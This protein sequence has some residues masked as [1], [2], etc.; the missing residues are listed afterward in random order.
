MHRSRL[1]ILAGAVLALVSLPL[2]HIRLPVAGSV[3]GFDG[4]SWPAA[5]LLVA[6]A[7]LAVAGDRGEGFGAA[8]AV[9]AIGIAGIAVVFTSF[10]L[11]D[12]LEAVDEAGS[13]GIGMWVLVAGALSGLAGSVFGL[14]R[15]L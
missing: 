10:K 1:V 3:N 6:L 2:P 4:D 13:I 9:A 12:G 15:K 11:A 14:S 5:L 8:Q 7:A